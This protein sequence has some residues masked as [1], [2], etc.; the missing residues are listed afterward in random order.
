MKVL[1]RIGIGMIAFFAA[2]CGADSAT[3]PRSPALVPGDAGA[4]VTDAGSYTLQSTQSGWMVE[5]RYHF[6]NRSDRVI[7]LLNCSGAY[8]IRLEKQEGDRWVTAWRPVLPMCLSQPIRIGAGEVRSDRL[9]LFAGQHG[10]NSYPQFE[11]G[12]IGGNYRLVIESAF[13]GYDHDG[14][15][16]GEQPP[17]E[18][19]VSNVF[20]LRTE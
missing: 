18:Y 6:T 17:L 10:S 1:D 7:S 19:R 8:G 16:W 20:E 12:E 9:H 13:W 14:P 4:I 15:P 3:S 2:A 5:I 11:T